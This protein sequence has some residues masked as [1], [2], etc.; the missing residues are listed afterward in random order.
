MIA[1]PQGKENTHHTARSGSYQAHRT[2]DQ[3]RM[4]SYVSIVYILNLKMIFLREKG[5]CKLL[6]GT[7]NILSNK[8]DNFHANILSIPACICVSQPEVLRFIHSML[9]NLDDK[10]K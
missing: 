9:F 5:G 3:N 1:R 2:T 6:P 7:C 8:T 10:Q 4:V